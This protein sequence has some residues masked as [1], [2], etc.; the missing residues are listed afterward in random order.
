MSHRRL[1]SICV[2]GVLLIAFIAVIAIGIGQGIHERSV[3]EAGAELEEKT[4]WEEAVEQ[5][6]IPEGYPQLQ[7]SDIVYVTAS[8]A[9]FHLY[10]DCSSLSRSKTIIG[11]TFR[12]AVENGK[13]LC[14][15]CKKRYNRK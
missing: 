7:D 10:T 14:S 8:G 12:D 5:K 3:A 11:Q 2:I 15:F 6:P 9:K 13:E 4:P 1:Q